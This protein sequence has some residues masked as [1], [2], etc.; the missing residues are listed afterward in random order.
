[1]RCAAA[2]Q[3]AISLTSSI[4]LV[5]LRARLGA[6]GGQVAA[7][8]AGAPATGRLLCL[9]LSRIR[10]LDADA[11]TRADRRARQ[12]GVSSYQR[13]EESPARSALRSKLAYTSIFNLEKI[14][15]EQIRIPQ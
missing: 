15:A 14:L 7:L 13:R 4:G 11:L 3:R 5:S 9:A 2:L 10:E 1:M 12:A 6:P 8:L